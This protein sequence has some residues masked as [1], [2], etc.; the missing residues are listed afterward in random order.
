LKQ[1][2][3]AILCINTTYIT[4][5]NNPAQRV[6]RFY[7]FQGGHFIVVKGYRVVDGKTYFETYDPNNWN[8][9]YQSGQEKGKDRYFLSEDL[10]KAGSNHWNYSIIVNPKKS[11]STTV[12]NDSTKSN[13]TTKSNDKLNSN[14]QD[15]SSE[16]TK[17][18]NS[19]NSRSWSWFDWFSWLI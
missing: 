17:S 3:I 4:Y 2:N 10:M 12:S 18:S 14:N 6:G 5:N 19:N 1:G 8:E 16:E 7:S 13:D 9:H 11:A 15:D